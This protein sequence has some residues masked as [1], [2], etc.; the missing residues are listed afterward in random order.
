MLVCQK[1]IKFKENMQNERILLQKLLVLCLYTLNADPYQPLAGSLR[2]IDVFTDLSDHEVFIKL[3]NNGKAILIHVCTMHALLCTCGC[4]VWL[5]CYPCVTKYQLQLVFRLLVCPQSLHCII[6]IQN[7]Y[8]YTT[9]IWSK[10][11]L[12]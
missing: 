6:P 4:T 9:R 7:I 8:T 12:G 10:T 1:W 5:Y 2:M 3:L 11:I